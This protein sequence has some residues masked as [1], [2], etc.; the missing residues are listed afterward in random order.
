MIAR[1]RTPLATGYRRA[2]VAG[3]L[4]CALLIAA[5][6]QRPA[7][8]F[9]E[10]RIRVGGQPLSVEV[11]DTVERR[12]LGLSFRRHLADDAGMLFVFPE[13]RIAGFVMYDTPID[14]DIGFFD[15]NG[16]LFEIQAMRAHDTASRYVPAAPARYALEVN[17][18]WF[19][20]HGLGAG[21]ALALPRVLAAD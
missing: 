7:A 10:I 20:G 6:Y 21:A 11:A 4:L 18:G 5:A 14:L 9:D 2:M 16:A 12:A 8:P 3:A 1:T 17:R 15:D 19:D 13:P